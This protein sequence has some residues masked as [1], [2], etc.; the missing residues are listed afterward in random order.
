VQGRLRR[1]ILRAGLLTALF[2]AFG[3]CLL[4]LTQCP[5]EPYRGPVAFWTS[6]IALF[7]ALPAMLFLVFFALDAVRLCGR[8]VGGL[9]EI[10]AGERLVEKKDGKPLQ[11][12]GKYVPELETHKAKLDIIAEHT[13]TVKHLTLYPF[14]V[15]LLM[16]VPRLPYLGSGGLP[17]QKVVLVVLAFLIAASSAFILSYATKRAREALLGPLRDG[18][19]KFT[20]AK[21]EKAHYADLYKQAIDETVAERR[22]TFIRICP[23]S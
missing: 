6:R 15:F 7:V 22:G 11:R 8:F 9:A 12:R 23:F 19:A 14:L 20:G 17:W 4:S 16:L 3:K 1:R 10:G 2:F 13:T 5:D 18:L 21:G